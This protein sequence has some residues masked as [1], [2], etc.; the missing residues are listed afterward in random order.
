MSHSYAAFSCLDLAPLYTAHS[1]SRCIL[2]GLC[3]TPAKQAAMNVSSLIMMLGL[4]CWLS[5]VATTA[6]A[7]HKGMLQH[8]T[9]KSG[10]KYLIRKVHEWQQIQAALVKLM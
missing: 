7:S 2:Y 9:V 1:G 8:M 5:K 10:Q 4:S 6:A 3:R